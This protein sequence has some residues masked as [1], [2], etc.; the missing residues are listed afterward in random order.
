[1]PHARYSMPQAVLAAGLVVLL[2]PVAVH[3]AEA[4]QPPVVLDAPTEGAVHRAGLVAAADGA[5]ELY[6]LHRGEAH[7]E[8]LRIRTTDDGKT[9]SEPER[10]LELP[11]PA[12]E[13]WQPGEWMTLRPLRSRDNELHFFLMRVHRWGRRIAVDRLIDVWY[14]GSRDGRKRWTKPVALYRGYVG[15]MR[16]ALQLDNGR[17]VFPFHHHYGDRDFNYPTGDSSTTV[18]YSDDGGDTWQL[19]PDELTAPVDPTHRGSGHG[20]VEP[21]AVELNDGWVWM[22]IRTQT[23]RLYESYSRDGIHWTAARPSRFFSSNSPAALL[24]LRD[25]RIVVFWNNTADCPAVDGSGVYTNRDV[26]HAAISDDDGRTWHGWREIYRDPYRNQTP[27]KRGDRGTAYPDAVETAD[28]HILLMTGHGAGRT[29]IIIVDPAW[30]YETSQQDDFSHGLDAWSVYKSVGDAEYYWRDR[31]V[32]AR[33]VDHPDKP[34]AKVLCLRRPKGEPADGAVWNFP[35]GKSGTLTFRLRLL[36]GCQGASFAL[37]DRFFHP[38]DI[39]GEQKAL[40]DLRMSPAHDLA[41]KVKLEIDRW[42]TIGMQWDVIKGLCNVTVD[43]EDALCLPLKAKET[44]GACYLR[45]R[46]T[47]QVATPGFL[48]ESVAVKVNG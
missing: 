26:L 5:I 48:I 32:G 11:G 25:G 46:S 4:L 34:G 42:Y 28:G 19:S 27:P 40:F 10:V 47:A 36:R 7:H 33:L 17:I 20:A 16:C 37:A 39:T 1:M 38:T 35:L 18:A 31:V 3:A 41:S 2:T 14:V 29:K 44:P 12:V 45:L 8:I 6:Y 13:S 43:G 22:L 24:K 23:G 9:W 21:V 15:D 30:L